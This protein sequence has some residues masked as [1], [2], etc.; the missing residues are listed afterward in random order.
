MKLFVLL[1]EDYILGLDVLCHEKPAVAGRSNIS[2]N[3]LHI[4]F[5]PVNGGGHVIEIQIQVSQLFKCIF[6]LLFANVHTEYI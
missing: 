6:I 4:V 3:W 1:L 2:M 5:H